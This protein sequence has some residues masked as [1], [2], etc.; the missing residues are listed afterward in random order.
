MVGY[1]MMQR[2]MMDVL[3]KLSD[4]VLSTCPA[5]GAD[6][7]S[8]QVTAAG[9]QLKGSGSFFG[10]V[11]F[12]TKPLLFFALPAGGFFSIALLMAFFNALER[13]LTGG[14]AKPAAGGHHG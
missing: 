12:K 4:P 10:I 2:S 14:T 11:L 8:K 9:F 1:S 7:F 13:K 5:C 6:A 3:Q